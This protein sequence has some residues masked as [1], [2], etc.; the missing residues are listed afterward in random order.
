MISVSRFHL[1]II[2][3]IGVW[4]GVNASFFWPGQSNAIAIDT[5]VGPEVPGRYKHAPSACELPNGDFLLV[6]YSG[7]EEYGDDTGIF[8]LRWEHQNRAWTAPRII[9]DDPAKPEGNPVVW[10]APDDRIWL[11]Y[12]VRHGETWSTATLR[13]KVSTDEGETWTEVPPPTSDRGIMTRARPIATSNGDYL[14]PVDHNPST[15]TEFVS[16][17]SCSFFLRYDVKTGTWS[18]TP[19]IRSRLGN[20]QPSVVELDGRRL[21][22]YCRRGGDYLGR[23]DGF[24]VRSTSPDGGVT[25][26]SGEDSAFPN[27]NAPAEIIKLKNGHL[28]LA[29]NDSAFDRCS[30]AV[31][32][33]TDNDRSYPRKRQIIAGENVDYSYPCL[34]EASDGKIHLFFSAGERSHIMHAHFAERAIL[35]DP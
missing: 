25:W 18:A 35:G 16:P 13:A 29:Y 32:V 17:D 15:D 22:A 10:R 6:Y 23:P 30:L 26:T 34:I 33:S 20:H 7:T 1:V 4:L 12:P 27:P 21:V 2:L 28:L 31:A 19:K 5:V 24:L 11:F 3:L 14:L 9:V 8:G